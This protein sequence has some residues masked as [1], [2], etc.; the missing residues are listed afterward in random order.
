[1]II[2]KNVLTLEHSFSKIFSPELSTE[3]VDTEKDEKFTSSRA[4]GLVGF[5][6]VTSEPFTGGLDHVLK[7]L[8][9]L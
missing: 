8:Y 9:H 5:A 6:D 7:C 1:M 3:P 2:N 4:S